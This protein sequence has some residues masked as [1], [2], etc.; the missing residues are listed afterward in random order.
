[1]PAALRKKVTDCRTASSSSMTWTTGSDGAVI[2][3]VLLRHRAQREAEYRSAAG[4]C[5]GPDSAAVR[6]DDRPADREPDPHA[7]ALRR[8]E[9]LEQL[10]HDLWGDADAAVGHA[11]LDHAALGRGCHQD[12]L[13]ALRIFHGFQG[14]S[15]QIEDHLLDLHF[16][17]KNQVDRSVEPESDAYTPILD[18]DKGERACFV[19]EPFDAFDLPLALTPRDEIPQTP[20]DLPRTQRL[21]GGLVY[22]LE[23]H[24]GLFVGARLEQLTRPLHI[25]TDGRKRLVELVSESRRHLTHRG[26]AGYVHEFGLQLLQARLGLLPLGEI[27]DESGEEARVVGVHLADRKL[28]RKG[29][30]ILAL[31]HHNS[32]HADDPFLP[33]PQVSYEV[34]VMV[35]AVRR[36][37]HHIDVL[38]QHFRSSI[39]EQAFCCRAE[40]LHVP[41]FINHDHGVGYSRKD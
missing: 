22:R 29:R 31:A 25:A 19:D 40:R 38:A 27:A 15:H 1:M 21:L 34:A 6:F 11:D 7:V 20:D 10:R 23:R 16:V 33:R 2:V 26:Q 35:F 28:H 18:A 17:G 39:A 12:Q 5:I 8:D 4:I 24:D 3:H 30:A 9:R 14:V 41:A 36:G 37:H 13:A 32:S